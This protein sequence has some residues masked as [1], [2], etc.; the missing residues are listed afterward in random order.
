MNKRNQKRLDGLRADGYVIICWSEEDMPGKTK[1]DRQV[2]LDTLA[3]DLEARGTEAGW[4]V[5]V[6]YEEDDDTD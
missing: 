1:A 2:V 5:V 3:D 4:N 6:E